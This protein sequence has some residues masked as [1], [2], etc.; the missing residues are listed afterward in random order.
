MNIIDRVVDYSGFR[1]S[2]DEDT[3]LNSAL[4]RV[5]ME[6]PSDSFMKVIF[7]KTGS[8]IEG[9]L[10]VTSINGSF[11]A[12][13]KGQEVVQLAESLIKKMREQLVSWKRLRFNSNLDFK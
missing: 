11:L 13:E 9:I 6:S 7:T 4:E 12:R 3:K 1:P 8:G 2:R 5:H 10:K